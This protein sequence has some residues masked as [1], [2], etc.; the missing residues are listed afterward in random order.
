MTPLCA[1]VPISI[2]RDGAWPTEDEQTA[3]SKERGKMR[4]STDAVTLLALDMEKS[5]GKHTLVNQSTSSSL[6]LI[7]S[8]ES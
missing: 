6:P 7:C 2:D 3:S 5:S 4:G 1:A 8:L